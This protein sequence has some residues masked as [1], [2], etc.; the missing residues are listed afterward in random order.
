MTMRR[1]IIMLVSLCSLLLSACTS[2][3]TAVTD[4]AASNATTASSRDTSSQIGV[5]IFDMN[6]K[7]ASYIVQGM[8]VTAAK[9]NIKATYV[10]AANNSQLQIQQV[11]N[12]IKDGMRTI[13]IIPSDA[14]SAAGSIKLANEANIPIIVVNHYYPEVDKATSYIGSDALTAG[15]MQMEAVA[16]LLHDKGNVAIM[17]G[18]V[19][20]DMQVKRTEGNKHVI[21][22]Y[23]DI[24]IVLEDAAYDNRAQGM[25]LM[26]KW[27]ASGKT[28]QAVVANND[29][30]II[31]AML[32]AQLAHKDKDMI[33]AGV[34]ATMDALEFMQAG[35]LQVTVF[36]NAPEQGAAAIQTA[37]MASQGKSVQKQIMI[38]YELVTRDNMEQYIAKWK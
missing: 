22:N 20:S 10:D 2:A 31:G 1:F 27:L 21:A 6:N 12:M 18:V 7:F 19:G 33:F 29:E 28:I 17:E 37:L 15:T 9:N 5:S 13:V 8:K 32:A 16:K 38:P 35:R 3:T 36:Q 26:H 11:A 34:D 30:M 23:P 24:H 14:A 4:T 25:T